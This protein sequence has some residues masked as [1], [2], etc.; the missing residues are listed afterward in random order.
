MAPASGVLTVMFETKHAVSVTTDG[1]AEI[2]VHVGLDTVNLKGEHYPSY[3]KQGEHVIPACRLRNWIR[4]SN[5]RA[6]DL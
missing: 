4:L 1:G 6:G 2:I 5:Y 3:K